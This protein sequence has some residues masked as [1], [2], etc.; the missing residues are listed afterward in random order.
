M[1][2]ANRLV[3]HI[4]RLILILRTGVLEK[5]LKKPEKKNTNSQTEKKSYCC[6]IRRLP[7][8]IMNSA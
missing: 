6:H 2:S 5:V 3:P 8:L 7:N 1:F 4:L